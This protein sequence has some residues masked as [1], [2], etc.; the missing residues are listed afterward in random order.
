[1]KLYKLTDQNHQTR[2]N[3]Q[4]GENIEYVASGEGKICGPGFIHAYIDSL[5][6]VLL[7][8]IHA[9]IKDPVLWEAEGDIVK[10]DYGLK[11]GC[12]RL[13]TIKIIFLPE[14][15]LEQR[16]K[17]SIL[18]A[19]EVYKE[20][21][22]VAW[23]N[24]WLSGEDRSSTTAVGVIPFIVYS[25]DEALTSPVRAYYS[26]Y[27]ATYSVSNYSSYSSYSSAQSVANAIYSAK[28]KINLIALSKK[29]CS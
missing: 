8:P 28:N 4:W 19:L 24:K 15:T 26:A 9:N 6:A 22:F 10:E 29:A 13:K 12:T 11:V 17:F 23:A 5:L 25:H 20:E 2:N 1:M 21:K 16:I 14:I 18:C 7:N 3:T 27:S